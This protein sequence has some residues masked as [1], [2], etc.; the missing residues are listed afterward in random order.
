MEA[1]SGGERGLL[2]HRYLN[3]SGSMSKPLSLLIQRN[4]KKYC[5]FSSILILLFAEC[6][7]EKQFMYHFGLWIVFDMMFIGDR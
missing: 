4:K 3:R 2:E 6:L 1:R 5:W 7:A